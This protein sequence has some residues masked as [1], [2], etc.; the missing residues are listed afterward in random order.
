MAWSLR[1]V[2]MEDTLEVA[3]IRGNSWFEFYPGEGETQTYS[4][5]R[6]SNTIT[7]YGFDLEEDDVLHVEYQDA[8]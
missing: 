1:Y 3:I 4:Y 6:P 8:I 2:P 5:D 7:L